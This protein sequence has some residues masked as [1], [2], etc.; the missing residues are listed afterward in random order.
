[1]VAGATVCQNGGIS[2]FLI[3]AQIYRIGQNLSGATRI[4]QTVGEAIGNGLGET[5]VDFL[6]TN[7]GFCIYIR[8][9]Q[10][11]IG[12]P[13]RLPGCARKPEDLR[14]SSEH[15]DVG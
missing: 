13:Q 15:R 3:R 5:I 4:I 2:G 1:M 12:R 6:D 7:T 11:D 10:N 8:A 9:H 14:V